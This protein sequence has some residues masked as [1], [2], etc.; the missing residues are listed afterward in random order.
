MNDSAIYNEQVTSRR[1]EILFVALTIV[2]LSL[3]FWRITVGSF[4]FLAAVFL[5][6]LALFLFYA[7]NYRTLSIR[8]TA[9]V[10]KLSFGIFRWVIPLNNISDCQLD[11]NLPGLM[12]YGGAGIH[13]MFI[14]KRYRVSFN[15]LEYPRVVIGLKKKVGWVRDVSFSTC[16]PDEL[17]RLIQGA[18]PTDGTA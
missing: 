5:F 6:F 16:Q 12:K 17:M 1:T 14:D 7:V 10:F 18:V 4:D 11:D 3:F 15:F 9:D 13:F 2:F 8:L